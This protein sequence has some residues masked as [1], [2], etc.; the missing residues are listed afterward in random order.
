ML[1]KRGL[2]YADSF[3]AYVGGNPISNVDPDG[4]TLRSNWNFFWNSTFG[5]GTRNRS[6]GPNDPETQEMQQEDEAD[7]LQKLFYDGRCKNRNG[8]AYCSFHTFRNAIYLPWDTA[9]QVGG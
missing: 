1:T 6:Y 4:P 8:V 7:V 9:F 2:I 3:Y 5:W